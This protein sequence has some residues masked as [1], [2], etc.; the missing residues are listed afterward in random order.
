MPTILVIDAS[1]SV[2]ETLRIVLRQEYDVALVP[3]LG[4]TPAPSPPALVIL[5]LPLAPSEDRAAGPALDALAPNVPVLLL[6]A[7][8]EVDVRRLVPPGR[9]VGFLPKPFDAYALR[10]R[11]RALLAEPASPCIDASQ[12]DH[13]RRF[14]EAPFLPSSAAFVARQAIVSDVPVLLIGEPGTG[15]WEIARAIH[16]FSGRSG[17]FTALRAAQLD[18]GDLLGRLPPAG[19]EEREG[20]TLYIEGVHD[21]PPE[22]YFALLTLVKGHLAPGTVAPLRVLASTT[23]NLGVRAAAGAFMPELAHALSTV[24]IV[25]PPLRERAADVPALVELLTADLTTRLRLEPVTYT[26]AAL[27]CLTRYQWFG[28]IAELEA[29]LGRT[30][31]VHRPRLVEPAHLVFFP[32][33]AVAAV[34]GGVSRGEGRGA[35]PG[36]APLATPNLE[37]LLGELAHELRNPMVTIKTFAQHLDSVLDDAEVRTRFSD[38]TVEAVGRMDALLETLLDFAR[39]RVPVPQPTDLRTIVVRALDE[40]AAEL[41]RRGIRVERDDGGPGAVTV[42][43]DEPQV[44][45]ALRNLLA[46]LIRDL[47]PHEPLRVVV[48]ADGTLEIRVHME[49]TTAERLAAYVGEGPA[50]A[51]GETPPL[52][53]ALAT[54]LLARN[55]GTLT[56][57]SPPGAATVITVSWAGTRLAESRKDE[58]CG[59]PRS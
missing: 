31:A 57:E 37:V 19:A 58:G 12:A 56:V 50:P 4:A 21:A 51:A 38:L 28:N 42:R 35:V 27:D 52:P 18:A 41:A 10:S 39:F 17:P 49:P 46:G 45:F 25:L 15:A 7:P 34:A 9:R 54:A 55:G 47:M 32:E 11:V 13:Q 8:T 16:F 53:F 3:S 1:A 59:S 44:L 36:A 48:R 33:E 40:H 30:L 24:A 43:A 14:L 29:V 2:R 6:N 22:T 20:G 5:G 23:E 26:E